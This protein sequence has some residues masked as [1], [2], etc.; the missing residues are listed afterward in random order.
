M[1]RREFIIGGTATAWPLAARA[2]QSAMPIVGFVNAASPK[3]LCL[4]AFLKG[5]NEAGFVD[6]HRRIS[7]EYRET[8]HR[9]FILASR[10]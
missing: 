9:S 10:Y 5:L 6:G 7:G 8:Y 1:R 2:Q 3:G 4:S